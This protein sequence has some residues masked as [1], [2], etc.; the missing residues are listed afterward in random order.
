MNR[1]SS[2][3]EVWFAVP[4]DP[5]TL[6]G[7]YSYAKRL[8]AALRALGWTVHA[9]ALP[10][11]YPNPSP[12]DIAQTQDVLRGLPA[13]ATVLIDGLAFGAFTPA[14]LAGVNLNISALVHHPLALETGLTPVQAEAFARRERE[15]LQAA[16][17]IIATS[18]HTAGVI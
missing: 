5:E 3:P 9:T 14:V 17:A 7:G 8:S 16:H 12:D 6:T 13:G 15:A 11:G 18:P 10:G 2:L 1:T 4:G